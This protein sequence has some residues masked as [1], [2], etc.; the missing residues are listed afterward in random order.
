M[1]KNFDRII[2]FSD[3]LTENDGGTLTIDLSFDDSSRIIKKIKNYNFDK[4]VSKIEYQL[5]LFK[6]E[7]N[8][9]NESFSFDIITTLKEKKIDTIIIKLLSLLKIDNFNYLNPKRDNFNIYQQIKKLDDNEQI[10]KYY[11]Y[12]IFYLGQENCLISYLINQ[13]GTLKK[14]FE[15][16]EFISNLYEIKYQNKN[17]L[18]ETD[19]EKIILFLFNEVK[20]KIVSNYKNKITNNFFNFSIS[21]IFVPIIFYYLLQFTK[22]FNKNLFKIINS[23]IKYLNIN[24]NEGLTKYQKKMFFG[25][26]LLLVS[27]YKLKSYID[28][29]IHQNFKIFLSQ[30]LFPDHFDSEKKIN[31]INFYEQ[32]ESFELIVNEIIKHPIKNLS[33]VIDELDDNSQNKVTYYNKKIINI[34]KDEIRVIKQLNDPCCAI[35]RK[36]LS[37]NIKIPIFFFMNKNCNLKTKLECMGGLI[38]SF[39]QINKIKVVTKF[40]HNMNGGMITENILSFKKKKNIK[41]KTKKKNPN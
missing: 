18:Y 14:K 41:K 40:S 15:I 16:E 21:L 32:I 29:C 7:L 26:T 2:P 20:K 5:D 6:E 33:Q 22:L 30:S 1:T 13:D 17:I 11:R 31:I 38:Y 19:L 12:W 34:L 36:I 3:I 25:S 37:Y 9:S 35:I 23:I 8:D 24:E 10:A 27:I 28:N 4:D 39:I